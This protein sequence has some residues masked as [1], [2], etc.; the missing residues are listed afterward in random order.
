MDQEKGNH[1]K[2]KYFLT[3]PSIYIFET[4]N[5]AK[6]DLHLGYINFKNNVHPVHH[7][8][9][10]L[11][12]LN[13]KYSS[14]KN[15]LYSVQQN[16]HQLEA[17]RNSLKFKIYLFLIFSIIT[18]NYILYKNFLSWFCVYIMFIYC[19]YTVFNTVILCSCCLYIMQS[20]GWQ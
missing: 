5:F 20:K 1:V 6:K 18:I 9:D 16:S 8:C 17:K 13:I 15:L 10:V 12:T 7:W 19:A 2:L 4:I 11:N 3:F 14:S